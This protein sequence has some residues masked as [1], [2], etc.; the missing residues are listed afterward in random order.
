MQW[1]TFYIKSR[2]QWVKGVCHIFN[3]FSMVSRMQF[4]AIVWRLSYEKF[5]IILKLNLA[6]RD[7]Q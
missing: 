6:K 3:P 4:D 2:I 7:V 1:Y 5:N